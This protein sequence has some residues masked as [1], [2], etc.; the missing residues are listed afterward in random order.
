M[1]TIKAFAWARLLT[2]GRSSEP[3]LRFPLAC[4][5]AGQFGGCHLELLGVVTRQSV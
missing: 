1:Y 5:I 3:P 4:S 2:A